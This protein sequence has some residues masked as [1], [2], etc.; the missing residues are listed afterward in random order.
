M[1]EKLPR[2]KGKKMM[3]KNF[4]II[5]A[6]AIKYIL[7]EHSSLRFSIRDYSMCEEFREK[8]V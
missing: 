6:V 5:P 8:M 1:K 4:W 3:K 2:H 7:R